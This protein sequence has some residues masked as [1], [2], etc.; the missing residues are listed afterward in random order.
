MKRRSI[1]KI[2]S[3]VLSAVALAGC[4]GSDLNPE[5]E[6]FADAYVVSKM[7]SGKQSYAVTYYAYGNQI[8]NSGTVVQVGGS[9]QQVNLGLSSTSI[10][11]LTKQP[12]ESDYKTVIPAAAEYQFKITSESGVVKNESDYL[13]PIGLQI[14]TVL[15][16]EFNTNKLLDISWTPVTGANGYVIKIINAAGNTAYSSE[17]LEPTVSTFSINSL[18]VN[19]VVPID[20]DEVV[21]VQVHAFAYEKN[22]EELYRVY[23]VEEI[24]VGQ[25]SLVWK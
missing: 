20:P 8:L 23:N 11:V 17:G 10:F 19:W 21:N 5:V 22:T 3:I 12:A 15:K 7:V 14:P 6:V 1:V 18:L 9:G 16:A 4:F 24:S 25:K 2:G 13:T